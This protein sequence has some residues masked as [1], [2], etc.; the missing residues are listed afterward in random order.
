MAPGVFGP[1]PEI[2]PRPAPSAPAP[3]ARA[4]FGPWAQSSPGRFRL[5][6][7]NSPGPLL[8]RPGRVPGRR[9][10]WRK[11]VRD[12]GPILDRLTA[13]LSKTLDFTGAP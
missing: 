2:A 8:P 5:M 11:G 10:R 13:L 12:I 9:A 4:I 1:W 3:T 7:R 6:G